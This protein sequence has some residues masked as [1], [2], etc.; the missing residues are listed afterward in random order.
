MVTSGQAWAK[1]CDY[2]LE[3]EDSIAKRSVEETEG[4]S[5]EEGVAP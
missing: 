3:G 5:E 2:C 1:T 4:H